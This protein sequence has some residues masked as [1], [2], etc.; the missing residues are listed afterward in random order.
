M[1]M[2]EGVFPED[3]E[4]AEI[5]QG[6]RI[7]SGDAVLLNTGFSSFRRENYNHSIFADGSPGWQAACLPWL[8]ER[9]VAIIGADGNNEV[10]PNDYIEVSKHP[11]HSV[12]IAMMGLWLIDNC[13]L[14]KL[15][16]A[17]ASRKQWTFL[18]VIAPFPYRGATGCPVNPIA[19]L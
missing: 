8:R 17:C 11:I 18:I 12:A 6:V 7:Q 9:D 2:G 19:I 10:F 16:E 4:E 15:A 13:E 1:E 3:L 5:R 14:E